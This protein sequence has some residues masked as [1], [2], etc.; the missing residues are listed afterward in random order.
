MR[1]YKDENGVI[2]DSF[3][4]DRHKEYDDPGR[5]IAEEFLNQFNYEVSPND[6]KDIGKINYKQPDLKA[7]RDGKQYTFEV[8]VKQGKND[9]AWNAMIAKRTVHIPARKTHLKTPT[10]FILVKY[11][12]S[13]LVLVSGSNVKLCLSKNNKNCRIITKTFF[14]KKTNK[15][16]SSQFCEIPSGL[17]LRY[18]KRE[19]KW[20]IK[21]W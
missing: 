15:D 18:V 12:F 8:E 14:H 9:N 11:D 20:A 17:S 10:A 6:G 1:Q 13:E 16:V 21:P 2:C 5:K 19:G 3:E 7:T 4:K